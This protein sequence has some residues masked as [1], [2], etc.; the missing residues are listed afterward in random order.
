MEFFHISRHQSAWVLDT[1]AIVDGC[2]VTVL[3]THHTDECGTSLLA[4]Y[5]SLLPVAQ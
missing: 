2:V 5:P 3:E 1:V 4:L